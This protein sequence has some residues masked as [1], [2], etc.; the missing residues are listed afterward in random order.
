M[1]ICAILFQSETCQGTISYNNMN[2]S[3]KTNRPAVVFATFICQ[4]IFLLHWKIKYL[5]PKKH[6]ED[7]LGL[8]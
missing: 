3:G 5:I 4:N 8:V 1:W 6:K 2:V 7:S